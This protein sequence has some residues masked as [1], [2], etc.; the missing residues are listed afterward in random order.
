MADTVK[1]IN[2]LGRIVEIPIEVP[3]KEKTEEQNDKLSDVSGQFSRKD[4]L[5]VGIRVAAMHIYSRADKYV[6]YIH[7]YRV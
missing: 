6:E 2:G 1:L 4:D 7:Q 5:I 3:G